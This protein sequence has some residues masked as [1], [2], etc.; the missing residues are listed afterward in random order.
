MK[1]NKWLIVLM[2]ISIIATIYIYGLLPDR[3]PTHWNMK[4]EIDDYNGRE[5]VFF[6]AL[7]PLGLYLLMIII[8]KIDPR[9]DSYLK[10]KKAYTVIILLTIIVLIGI[11]WV[12][13][14]AAL[15]YNVNIGLIVKLFLGLL[16]VVMGNYMGQIRHN[17]TF[18]IRTPWTLANETVWKKTHRVGGYGFIISGITFIISAFV[19]NTFT[20]VLSFVIVIGIV[21]FSFIYSY[22]LYK[23]LPNKK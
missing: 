7:L 16:F 8:P 19:D 20:S 4:G 9:R 10:H 15:G 6:T 12:S 3:I 23:K 14:L 22:V 2:L 1:I 5:F 11:H 18:G 17:Y 13:I 21:V